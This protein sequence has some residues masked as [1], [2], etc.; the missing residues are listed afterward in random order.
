MAGSQ[1]GTMKNKER[2]LKHSNATQELKITRAFSKSAYKM[3]LHIDRAE[4][5]Q[6]RILTTQVNDMRQSIDSAFRGAGKR[7]TTRIGG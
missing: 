7:N 3:I 6:D 2:M 5:E 1:K 4:R